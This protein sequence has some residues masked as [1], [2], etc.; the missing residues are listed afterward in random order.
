MRWPWQ[1]KAVETTPVVSSAAPALPAGS[2]AKGVSGTA[3]W[4]GELRVEENRKLSHI[5]AFGGSSGLPLG[6]WQRIVMTNPFVVMGLEFITG[7][8][9]DAKW[10]IKAADK[11][12]V[13]DAQKH[14]DFLRWN[15]ENHFSPGISDVS[16]EGAWGA[17]QSGFA[18]HEK[19]LDVVPCP[20]MPSGQ[21]TILSKLVER[22][23]NSLKVNAWVEGPSKDLEM[24]R[25][26][27]PANDGTNR[28]IDVDLSSADVLLYTWRRRGNNYQG[29]SAFRAVYAPILIQDMLIKLIGIS[30][31]REGAGIPVAHTDDPNA[32]LT[33]DQYDKLQQFL[34]NLVM[35][36]QASAVMPV[37][38]KMDWVY[39][40]GANKGHVV[41]AYNAMGLVILQQVQAQQMVLGTNETGSRAVGK[42]HA[43]ASHTQVK[44]AAKLV[45]NVWNGVAGRPY[46]GVLKQLID[47]NFGPQEAYPKLCLTLE[48]AQSTPLEKA[49]ATQAAVSAGLFTVTARDENTFREDAGYDP[50][51]EDE[52]QQLI[53]DKAAKALE[54][55]QAAPDQPFGNKKPAPGKPAPKKPAPTAKASARLT[56]AAKPRRAPRPSEIHLSVD[57]IAGF[58]DTAREHFETLMRP[59]VVK[60]LVAA[61]P[62]IKA[63]MADGDPSE[64]TNLKLDTTGIE[65]VIE[66]ALRRARAEG[67]RQVRTELHRATRLRAAAGDEKDPPPTP[68]QNEV[69]DDEVLLQAQKKSLA[70]RIAARM[71]HELETEAIDAVRTGAK[72]E[73]IISRTVLS[74]LETGQLKTDAGII[75]TRAWNLGR[76]EAARALGA[77]EVEYSALMDDATCPQCEAFDGRTAAVNSPE[78]DALLPPNKDCD[79]WG[80]CRCCLVY[81]PG[82]GP[83]FDQENT[84]E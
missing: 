77:T 68:P 63:A 67:G 56:A 2:S 72:T 50:I 40:P 28:I 34:A 22:L 82:D 41:D 35:H 10:D 81:V 29:I 3:N 49:Q 16:V 15:L 37:G 52:R 83:G 42:V 39:S 71:E 74:Q 48:K 38:W 57:E 21:A 36:E 13:P 62:A 7:P 60:M 33:P 55:A 25:Q 18:I 5:S 27:G 65:T 11:E 12:L 45:E 24:I 8:I 30:L 14:A 51:D 6:E 26:Q 75:I 66:S 69:D 43:A 32:S 73:E 9:R 17:M 76:D 31:Q 70:K 44:A 53:D 64:L 59:E 58:L 80:N 78:H 61:G 19:V 84:D 54:M 1:K 79:G 4:G 23:P 20:L 47:I 46:T